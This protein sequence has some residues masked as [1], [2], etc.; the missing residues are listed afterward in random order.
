MA[1]AEVASTAG[2]TASNIL[3]KIPVAIEFFRS[4]IMKLMNV[5]HLPETGFL[6]FAG[7]LSLVFAYLW[8]KQF[9]VSGFFKLSAILNI[10]L[11]AL[12][13]YLVLV[14]V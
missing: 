14:Y 2:S 3:D 1:I 10:V 7:I 8:L 13:F 9:V 11:L 12:V 6:I 5:L 4:L